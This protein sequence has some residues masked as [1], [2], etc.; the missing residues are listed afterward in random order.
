MHRRRISA[1]LSIRARASLLLISRIM[2]RQRISHA[3]IVLGIDVSLP[4]FAI[5][6]CDESEP[7]SFYIP[8]LF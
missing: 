4:V 1:E 7:F 2:D 5:Y 3:S 8:F 6:N